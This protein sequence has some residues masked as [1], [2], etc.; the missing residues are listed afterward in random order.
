MERLS[1]CVGSLYSVVVVVDMRT[2]TRAHTHTYTRHSH[3]HAETHMYN[4]HVQA[5]RVH[6]YTH[7]YRRQIIC[8]SGQAIHIASVIIWTTLAFCVLW[9]V[10]LGAVYMHLLLQGVHEPNCAHGHISCT[11]SGV[12][13]ADRAH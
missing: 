6:T 4:K 7:L 13:Q 12:H 11:T 8:L 3:A 2:L 5:L 10:H 1:P 9:H